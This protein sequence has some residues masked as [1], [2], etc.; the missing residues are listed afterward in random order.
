MT[1]YE[2]GFKEAVGRLFKESIKT[3]IFNISE[4]VDSPTNIIL[5]SVWGSSCITVLDNN[6]NPATMEEAWCNVMV[7]FE[8]LAVTSGLRTSVVIRHFNM[9]KVNKLISPNGEIHVFLEKPVKGKYNDF[10]KQAAGN[11]PT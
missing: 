3:P 7:D 4:L 1:A 10:I 6:F 5:A 11:K 2:T 8:G 9:L